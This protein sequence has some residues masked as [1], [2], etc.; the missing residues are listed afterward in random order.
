MPAT[1]PPGWKQHTNLQ[2]KIICKL[3]FHLI[4]SSSKKATLRKMRSNHVFKAASA[5][6]GSASDRRYPAEH[7]QRLCTMGGYSAKSSSSSSPSSQK[8]LE[9]YSHTYMPICL[10]GTNLVFFPMH[11]RR[12]RRQYRCWTRHIPFVRAH[13]LH[14]SLLRSLSSSGWNDP[15][16][17]SVAIVKTTRL[18]T[19]HLARIESWLNLTRLGA[20]GMRLKVIPPCAAGDR[21]EAF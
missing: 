7:Q 16:T 14:R 21:N 12:R 19:V 17:G 6:A 18:A 2:W 5:S 11:R 15:G 13:Y 20:A 10:Y 9:P 8:P 1:K 3:S 4:S